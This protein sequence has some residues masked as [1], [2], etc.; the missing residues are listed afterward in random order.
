[1]YKM[2]TTPK[3]YVFDSCL[4]FLLRNRSTD[5]MGLNRCDVKVAVGGFLFKEEELDHEYKRYL[6]ITIV[7]C[8]VF[9]TWV[10][11]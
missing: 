5:P 4:F 8:V 2:T 11:Q 6:N 1:M 10:G 7:K 3:A 9:V